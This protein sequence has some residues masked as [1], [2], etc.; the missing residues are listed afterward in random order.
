MNIEISELTKRQRKP[1]GQSSMDKPKTKA[2]TKNEEIQR[3][4]T[5]HR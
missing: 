4:I 3:K 1:K 5:Q 2:K